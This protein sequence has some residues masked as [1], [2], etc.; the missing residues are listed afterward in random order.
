MYSNFPLILILLLYTTVAES[1]CPAECNCNTINNNVTCVFNKTDLTI[2]DSIPNATRVLQVQ[3][4]NPMQTRQ[5]A[6]QQSLFPPPLF[7]LKELELRNTGGTLDIIHPVK[8]YAFQN[9]KELQR[10]TITNSSVFYIEPKAFQGLDNLKVLDLSYNRLHNDMTSPPFHDLVDLTTLVLSG[11]LLTQIENNLFSNLP[12]LEV[13]NL[14]NNRI[15]NIS[16]DILLHQSQTLEKLDISGNPLKEFDFENLQV[17]HN[18]E[19]L[20]LSQTGIS[21]IPNFLHNLTAMPNLETLDL[22]YNNLTKLTRQDADALK[23]RQ[24][25]VIFT[26]N[27]W[28]CDCYIRPLWERLKENSNL[29][30]GKPYC[31]SPAYVKGRPVSSLQQWEVANCNIMAGRAVTDA[32][33]T[34][35]GIIAVAVSLFF[36]LGAVL[37]YTVWTFRKTTMSQTSEKKEHFHLFGAQPIGQ[38]FDSNATGDSSLPILSLLNSETDNHLN[39]MVADSE[40]MHQNTNTEEAN[41][42]SDSNPAE[43]E[44]SNNNQPET[45]TVFQNPVYEG[46]AESAQ[47]FVENNPVYESSQ[48]SSSQVHRASNGNPK[49]TGNGT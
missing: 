26:G 12:T 29:V 4:L 18:L 24:I 16:M 35:V 42:P 49:N 40:V 43:T 6:L 45:E 44:E 5:A 14:E 27:P 32:V 7:N 15:Q 19:Y 13:L 48:G 17:L 36:I 9:L 23:R 1:T 10:L 2:P 25:K 30:Y 20:D 3:F 22:R 33:D 46:Q 34:S 38:K 47:Q 21:D 8:N 11:N 41:I 28:L 39:T 31:A 37:I